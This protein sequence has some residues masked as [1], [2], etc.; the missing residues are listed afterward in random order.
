MVLSIVIPTYNRSEYLERT[1]DYFQEQ[2][3]RN[4]EYVNIKICNNA[5]TD[6]TALMLA[7]KR[8]QSPFFSYTDYTEHVEIGDSISRAN[9]S[10]DGDFILMWGDDDIPCPFLVDILLDKIKQFPH[11]SIFHFN[12]LSGK[13]YKIESINNINVLQPEYNKETIEFLS[14]KDFFNKYILDITFLSSVMF[15]KSKWIQNKPLDCTKHYGYEF[16]GH[17]FGNSEN[18]SIVYIEYPLCIQRHPLKRTWL[19]FSPYYRFIGIPNMLIDFEKWGLIYSAKDL[20]NNTINT[21]SQFLH[22]MAQASM[23]KKYY[24]PLLKEMNSH[25]NTISKKLLTFIFVYLFP[26]FIY[27]WIRNIV[28]DK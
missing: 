14:I 3:L 15:R 25:Q 9:D 20:W 2:I 7:E 11:A 21:K 18:D 13:D 23:Y 6:D 19:K 22:V 24:R 5:S 12:R 16:V 4:K 10:A 1:L 28:L 8:Q 27:R 26:G 17:I